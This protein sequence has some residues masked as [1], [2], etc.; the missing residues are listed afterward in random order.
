MNLK[1][2]IDLLREGN[3]GYWTLR[4]YSQLDFLQEMLLADPAQPREPLERVT[5]LLL[6]TKKAQGTLTRDDVLEAE[7]AL[8][9]TALRPSNTA[10]IWF[11]TRTSTWTGAGAGRRPSVS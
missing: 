6:R 9:A 1:K 4:L 11:P 10:C 8:P 7:R 5:E 3:D 2:R